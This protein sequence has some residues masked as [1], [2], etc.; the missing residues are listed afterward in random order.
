MN[1]ERSWRIASESKETGVTHRGNVGFTKE[2][3]ERAA[4]ATTAHV[5]E[6]Y[7]RVWAEEEADDPKRNAA[8]EM[9]TA[10][11]AAWPLLLHDGHS[12]VGI[13]VRAALRK[14]EWKS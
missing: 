12:D 2:E 10:L 1:T 8:C 7:C 11:E 14:A 13:Q 9:F 5:T 3:A 6:H 4:E